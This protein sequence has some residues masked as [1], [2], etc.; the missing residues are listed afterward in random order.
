MWGRN[1][2]DNIRRFLQ[3]QLTV[4]VVA[5]IVSF[6]GSVVMWDSP[7]QAIQLLWVNLIM[8]SLAS[9]ALATEEPKAN[10][11]ERPPYRKKEYIISQKMVKH[12]LGQAFFQAIILF[13]FVFGGRYMIADKCDPYT[14]YLQG[15]HPI[16]EIRNAAPIFDDTGLSLENPDGNTYMKRFGISA[17][18]ARDRMDEASCNKFVLDGSVQSIDG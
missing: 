1:V 3:F 17:K 9:L 15:S 6:I 18:E 10:L 11:L 8:D 4:N 5:L 2:Y 7:L 14:G 13:V 16:D 12:I